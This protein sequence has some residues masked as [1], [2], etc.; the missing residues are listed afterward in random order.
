MES[1]LTD[2]QIIWTANVF[3]TWQEHRADIHKL[4]IKKHKASMH[5]T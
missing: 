4:T 5:C 1:T 2:Y 3:F